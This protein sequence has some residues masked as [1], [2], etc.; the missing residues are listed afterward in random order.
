MSTVPEA[1]GGIGVDVVASP[2]SNPNKSTSGALNM[3]QMQA[4]DR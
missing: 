2:I 1:T 4:L 3:K